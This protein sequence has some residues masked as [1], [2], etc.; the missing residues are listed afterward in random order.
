MIIDKPITGAR[1]SALQATDPEIY[2]IIKGEERREV[3]HVELIAS[4]NYASAAVLEA[5]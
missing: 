2:D 4:E 3:A 5:Q 1:T